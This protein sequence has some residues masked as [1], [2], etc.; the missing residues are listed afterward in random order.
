MTDH[1]FGFKTKSL[2]AGS[3]PDPQTGSRTVPIYQS[4]AFVFENTE[5]AGDLFALRKFGNIYSRIGN[6]TVAAL[7]EKVAALEGGIGAVATASGLSAQFLVFASLAGSGDHIVASANL[8]GGTITQLD[9][10]MKKFGVSTT[11]VSSDDPADFAKAICF[12]WSTSVNRSGSTIDT[13]FPDSASRVVLPMNLKALLVATTW[14]EWPASE[15]RRIKGADLY[16]AIPPVTPTTTLAT[17]WCR[18][19]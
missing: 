1:Q 10:T 7:E 18:L 11:F 8:Y 16:A 2:H 14:T 12:T 6:P 3:S 19:V 5:D 17:C 15:N 9:V 13:G 4:T